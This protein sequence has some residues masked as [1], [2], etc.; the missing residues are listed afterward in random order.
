[1]MGA[2]CV[3]RVRIHTEG[4]DGRC[5]MKLHM[6]GG[7]ILFFAGQIV[8]RMYATLALRMDIKKHVKLPEGAKIIA[9]NHPSTTDPFLLCALLDGHTKLL[10]HEA[11]FTIPLFGA[12]LRG[13]GH[14]SVNPA[15]GYLAFNE[16][17]TAL[18]NGY[19]VGIFIEGG[20]SPKSG[21]FGAPK[22]GP[23]RLAMKCN[24]PVIPVGVALNKQN[25]TYIKTRLGAHLTE[26]VWLTKGPY[27]ATIG[28]PIRFKNLSG[29]KQSVADASRDIMDSI[30]ALSRESALRLSLRKGAK[31]SFNARLLR[32]QPYLRLSIMLRTV[33]ALL[34]PGTKT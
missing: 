23:A 17:V 11:L 15:H 8:I 21:G 2:L 32:F 19:N 29:S 30:M 12:Y 9:V 14:I 4:R 33:V 16:A 1:M 34:L 24:A 25:L 13:A 26:A 5:I 22:T 20:L 6:T 27:C 7:K 18:N 3:N 10:I 31:D 28:T